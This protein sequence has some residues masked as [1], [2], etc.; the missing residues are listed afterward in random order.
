M[1]WGLH[2]DLR[3]SFTKVIISVEIRASFWGPDEGIQ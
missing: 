1:V 3:V 2:F